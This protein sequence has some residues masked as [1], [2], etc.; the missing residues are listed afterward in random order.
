MVNGVPGG[1]VVAL[2]GVINVINGTGGSPVIYDLVA[3]YIGYDPP[4]GPIFV[5]SVAAYN[6]GDPV[7]G[8]RLSFVKSRY[9]F[10]VVV[11]MLVNN[12]LLLFILPLPALVC[13][14][15]AGMV[16]L[17]FVILL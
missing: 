8:R 5:L 4:V 15:S 17:A 13:Q 14:G 10:A 12:G 6:A 7:C 9:G 2:V 11:K 1:R 16:M 3:S